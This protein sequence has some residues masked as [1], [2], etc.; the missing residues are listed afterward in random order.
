MLN[1]PLASL[2]RPGGRAVF[3]CCASDALRTPPEQREGSESERSVR[4]PAEG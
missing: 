1:L 3:K 2:A 4:F